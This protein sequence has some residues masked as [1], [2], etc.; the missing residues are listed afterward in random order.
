V[1]EETYAAPVRLST[2]WLRLRPTAHAPAGVTAYSLRIRTEPH[3]VNW[4]RD[5]FE[6]HVARVDFPE[7]VRRLAIEVDLVTDVAATDPFDFLLDD[8][9][10]I[11][12]VRRAFVA[13]GLSTSASWLA[14]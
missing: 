8:G 13:A 2:H 3:F 14:A 10:R 4:M 1:I 9:G 12:S 11:R 7:P 6:N 5:A